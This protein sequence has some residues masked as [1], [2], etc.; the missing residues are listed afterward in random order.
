MSPHIALF[1]D[2]LCQS[3]HRRV[4]ATGLSDPQ[5][6]STPPLVLGWEAWLKPWSPWTCRAP[7][8][9]ALFLSLDPDV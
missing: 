1:M 4:R 2:S 6:C 7:G 5:I 9:L 8:M 3:R